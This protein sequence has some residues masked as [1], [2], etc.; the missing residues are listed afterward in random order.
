MAHPVTPPSAEPVPPGAP[1]CVSCGAALTGPYC[2]QCGEKR[3]DRHDYALGH[4]L[5]HTVDAFT[6]FDFKV[7]RSLWSLLRHPGQMTADVLA[8]RRVAWAKPI[9]VFLIANLVY[10][11]LAT[12]LHLSTFETPLHFHQVGPFGQLFRSLSIGAATRRGLT[13]AEYAAQF[14]ALAHT[15]AKTLVIFFVPMMALAFGLMAIKARRYALEHVTAALH[16]VSLMLLALPLP[17]PLVWTMVRMGWVE[18]TDADAIW[19]LATGLLIGVYGAR[20]MRQVYGSTRW[21]AAAQG[22]G[23]AVLFYLILI[24]LYR[25][26]LFFVISA[27]L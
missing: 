19:T 3:L 16:F 20:F 11:L 12:K 5:E 27:L 2:A 7:P 14:N 15:L 8:G 23:I 21:M 24:M 1:T 22:F 25:P 17:Y 10:Y 4:F 13:D 26:M 9:Q 18:R 6:H